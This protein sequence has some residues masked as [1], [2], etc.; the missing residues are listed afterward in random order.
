VHLKLHCNQRFCKGVHASGYIVS[1]Y[2]QVNTDNNLLLL[3]LLHCCMQM[4][5]V[6]LLTSC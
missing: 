5:R 2:H 3:L 6:T 1:Q 4:W